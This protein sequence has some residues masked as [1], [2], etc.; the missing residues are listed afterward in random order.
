M[1]KKS[2][3]Q[4]RSRESTRINL[5]QR[6]PTLIDHEL[7]TPQE[8]QTEPSK[9]ILSRTKV[10]KFRLKNL[11]QILLELKAQERSQLRKDPLDLTTQARPL[12][13]LQLSETKIL[14]LQDLL[15]VSE[16][17]QIQG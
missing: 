2:K 12:E 8:Q 5:L 3:T 15:Q 16:A 17:H 6:Q 9:Q 1:Q 11:H 4:E 10:L 7:G 13:P 14:K